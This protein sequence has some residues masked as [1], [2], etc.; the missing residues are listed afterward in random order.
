MLESP[1]CV[2]LF[3]GNRAWQ[4]ERSFIEAAAGDNL[5][6]KEA[7]TRKMELLRTELAGS[8]PSPL[9][10]LLDWPIFLHYLPGRISLFCGSICERV[11]LCRK[12]SLL[13]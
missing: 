2:D 4:A 7:V 5:V 9:E 10:R 1:D 12:V 13:A 8:S 3:G 11:R 6:Y